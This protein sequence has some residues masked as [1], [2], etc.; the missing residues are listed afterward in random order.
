MRNP[1]LAVTLALWG[2]AAVLSA[3]QNSPVRAAPTGP[4]A[5]PARVAA[6][7]AT[8]QQATEAVLKQY[9]V[10]CHNTRLKT[11]GLELDGLDMAKLPEHAEVWEKVVRKVRA[12]VMPPQGMRRPEPAALE[13]FVSWIEDGLDRDAKAHPNAGRPMLHRLNRSEY[14]NA[15]KDLLALDV[16]VASLLPPDDSAYGFDNISEIGR[17]HV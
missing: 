3:A 11:G 10:T 12:G 9:C 15:I 17:A 8:G 1:V 5:A 13:G 4:V 14:K 16:D 2:A 7:A 6:P